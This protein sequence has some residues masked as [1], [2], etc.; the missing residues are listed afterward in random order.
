MAC[1]RKEVI[2][3]EIIRGQDFA[4]KLQNLLL[5]PIGDRWQEDAVILIED[6]SRSIAKALSLLRSKESPDVSNFSASCSTD[7]RINMKMKRS[8]RSSTVDGRDGFDR[9]DNQFSRTVS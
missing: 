8:S 5:R 7:P 1:D 3:G 2:E 6:I 4:T 9:M